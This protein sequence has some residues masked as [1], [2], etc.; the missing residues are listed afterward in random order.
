[1]ANNGVVIERLSGRKL[2]FLVSIL[3]ALQVI[4]F[5]IGGLMCNIFSF[6]NWLKY[7]KLKYCGVLYKVPHATHTE[8][9]E[10][11][12]CLDKKVENTIK[13]KTKKTEETTYYL[14]D[15]LGR[16]NSNCERVEVDENVNK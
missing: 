16:V 13:A 4:F 14:R 15:Y 12:M 3:V 11:I 5:L 9:V 10:G 1:M 8:T 7:E 2:S 6:V